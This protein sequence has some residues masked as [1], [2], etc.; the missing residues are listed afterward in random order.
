MELFFIRQYKFIEKFK[1]TA[2]MQEENSSQSS[3]LPQ[4]KFD[5]P[6]SST[7]MTNNQTLN[8]KEFQVDQLILVP[9]AKTDKKENHHNSL[10]EQTQM[11]SAQKINSLLLQLISELK[12][13]KEEEEEV[14]YNVPM[15][16]SGWCNSSESD[17]G[18][19]KSQAEIRKQ[20]NILETLI[21]EATNAV[22]FR[23]CTGLNH[24]SRSEELISQTHASINFKKVVRK[25]KS[26]HVY[27]TYNKPLLKKVSPISSNSSIESE[28]VEN[29]VDSLVKGNTNVSIAELNNVAQKSSD[30]SLKPSSSE[31]SI[32]TISEP[33]TTSTPKSNSSV[34]LTTLQDF[35][36]EDTSLKSSCDENKH[37]SAHNKKKSRKRCT[38]W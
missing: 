11:S 38:L 35:K 29:F 26:H 32:S 4:L 3:D 18:E 36:A 7:N 6:T 20:N 19:A 23:N 9:S 27:P 24:K 17:V 33:A 22:S 15:P 2:S 16:S 31:R 10:N 34:D 37:I 30:S 28:D 8:S 5:K 1:L 13:S 14:E 25:C 21:K 12:N